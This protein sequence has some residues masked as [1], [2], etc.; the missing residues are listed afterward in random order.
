MERLELNHFKAFATNV[1][2]EN[3]NTKNILL[4]GENG[5]GKSS[6]FSAIEYIFYKDKIEMVDP[7]LPPAEQQ[8][9]LDEIREKYKNNQAH[10]PF[11]IKINGFDISVFNKDAY[12]VFMLNRFDKESS[13]SIRD[14]LTKN[15]FPID[16]DIDTY[17]AEK[18]EL[19]IDNVNIEL[20]DFFYEPIKISLGDATNGYE[21]VLKNKETQL[22]RSLEL[23]KFFNEAIINL[24]QLLIWFSAVQLAEDPTKKQIVVLDDFITSLDA[25]NRAYLMRYILRNF[26]HEQLVILTH[27]YSLFNITEFLVKHVFHKLSN[28][29]LYRLYLLGDNP[30]L[31]SISDIKTIDLKNQLHRGTNINDL[32]NKVRK[33]FEQRLH[34]LA[35]EL[36]VGQL[37]KTS[38][39]I[40]C[41]SKSKSVYLK[42]DASLSD[43]ISTIESM[44]PT[45]TDAAIRQTFQDK[46]DD[47]K[48]P[49][50]SKLKDTINLLK[51][52]QKVT[53]HPSSH[54]SLGAPHYT[55]KDVEES[56]RLLEELDKCIKCILDGRI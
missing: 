56:I 29:N 42:K 43:L 11:D 44:L 9:K 37:E 33:C 26:E 49:E 14:V 12:Q 13:I 47:Y 19:I 54:G 6:L 45:I 30:Q 38:D 20:S 53:M 40:E 2:L 32:G 39:I 35:A 24:V 23:D 50:A 48:V 10:V 15:F 5:A 7:M 28:W 1:V 55:R 4:F 21:I 36:S 31:D 3:A 16:V 25:A 46:I 22:S 41:I 34:D 17:I 18:Y 8:S 27:D 52:Y 51:F